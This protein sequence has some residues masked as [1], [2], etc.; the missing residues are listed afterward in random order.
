[1]SKG[2]TKAGLVSLVLTLL[3]PVG[4]ALAQSDAVSSHMDA[5]RVT[6]AADGKEVHLH[7]DQ[8]RGAADAV[9]ENRADQ[10]C[11]SGLHGGTEQSGPHRRCHDQRRFVGDHIPC[12]GQSGGGTCTWTNTG[13]RVHLI[14]KTAPVD[15][16]A[17]SFTITSS[18]STPTSHTIDAGTGQMSTLT[19]TNLAAATNLNE[20]AHTGWRGKSLNCVAT[21]GNGTET[22]GRVAFSNPA[23]GTVSQAYNSAVPANSFR[24]GNEYNCTF[25]NDAA[26]LRLAKNTN[27]VNGINRTFTNN[28]ASNGLTNGMTF[29]AA[30]GPSPYVALANIAAATAPR[31]AAVTD[32]RG[33]GMTCRRDGDNVVV[34]TATNLGTVSAQY[35]PTAVPANTFALGSSY[36]CTITN[37]LRQTVLTKSFSP[38]T[39]AVGGVTTL[40][41]HIDSAT[42]VPARSGM[43]FTDQL[44]AGLA[45][46]SD[47]V[48]AQCGGTVTGTAGS[49]IISL[50]GGS[51]PAG[52]SHCDIVVEVTTAPGQGAAVCP[53][54]STTNGAANIVAI[55]NGLVNGVSNQCVNVTGAA[56]PPKLTLSKVSLSGIGRFVFNGGAANAN[57]FPSDGSYEITT[58]TAGVPKNGSRVILSAADVATDIVELLPSGW[59]LTS[60]SCVDDNAPGN[61]NPTGAITPQIIGGNTIRIAP[62]NVKANAELKCTV[63]NSPG[64][65]MLTG[66]VILDNG[67]G[68]GT[69][70]DATQNGGETARVGVTVRLTNCG[71]TTYATAVTDSTGGFSFGL[72]GVP[73]G[74]VCV[75]KTA[76]TGFQ[77]VSANTGSTGGT[78]TRT[79]DTLSF[80][81]AANV[82]YSGI[83]LGEVPQSQLT[84]DGMQQVPPGG[85]A[86]YAHS[87]IAGTSAQVMFSTSD[88]ANSGGPWTSQIY[89]DANCNGQIDSGDAPILSP[90]TV[91]AGQTVCL[92]D[93]VY[94]P[95]GA[96][97]GMQDV[98][99][100]TAQ[101]TLN[102]VPTSGPLTFTY[103]R[104]DTTTT[105]QASLTLTK[106][107]RRLNSCPAN[108]A[109]SLADG[110]P[111]TTSNIAKSGQALEYSIMYRND[112]SIAVTNVLITD[113]VPAYSLFQ[114]ATCLNTPTTGLSGCSVVTMPTVNASSGAIEWKLLDSAASPR[115]LL[116]GAQ[117]SVSMCVK[118]Q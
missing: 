51:L 12:S 105:G 40:T 42:G 60:A 108:A 57:G 33:T 62:Q 107:V 36:T 80:A 82:S 53:N 31:E 15:G 79:N 34:H 55:S 101:E 63:T 116:P 93:R 56:S 10:W 46:A 17:Q 97:D 27:P 87:Y 69:A 18:N 61:G 25:T 77:P 5:Y 2:M 6:T 14:K 92:I 13:T 64:G 8:Q 118:V 3:V 52:P 50:S 22:L 48:A 71:S 85:V 73:A 86:T 29:N 32:W 76:T 20:G 41:L 89:S 38:T 35:T 112:T 37:E 78:Y 74:P 28:V 4:V 111:Y 99:T 30:T 70:H 7:L 83:V 91:I 104:T 44:P 102:P 23:T 24:A 49:D 9:K 54:A 26:L 110:T 114:S 106:R 67:I 98:T 58:A 45:I 90:V 21:T 84:T 115:G 94:V 100:V 59:T 11:Q 117:G 88:L 47:P 95:S 1:M 68:G 96:I 39:I 43:S 72:T 113:S 103:T 81:L 66:R 16:V 19:L 75:V 109:A 65:A